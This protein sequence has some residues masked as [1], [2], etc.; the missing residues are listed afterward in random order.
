MENDFSSL[1]VSG[2]AE[3]WWTL[4][5]RGIAAI[6]F[7][8]LA[9]FV[10]GSSL[11]ALV[12]LWGAYA[13]VEGAFNLALAFRRAGSGRTWGWFVLEGLLSVGAGVLTFLWPAITAMILV[14]IIGL[15][16]VFTGVVE[17]VAAIRL[18]RVIENEWLLVTSG[19]LSLAFGVLLFVFPGPGAL[20]LVWLIGAYALVFGGLLVALGLRLKSRWRGPRERHVPTH[21]APRP[22]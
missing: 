15:W 12:L 7:G 3:R 22:A 16:G 11:F 6:L 20:A 10:P 5:V 13:L 2:L 9:L 21:G 14:T 19:V 4:V 8:V 1:D 18:R 17:I